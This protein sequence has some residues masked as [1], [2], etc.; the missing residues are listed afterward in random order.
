MKTSNNIICLTSAGYTSVMMAIK[1]QEWYPNHN[2]INVMA[3]TSKERIESLEFMNECDKFFGLNL[4]WIESK[5][6]ET[7]G[8][9]TDFNITSFENLKTKGEIFEEGIKNMEYH[10]K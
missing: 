8:G 2:I 1:M 5:I 7:K 10:L 4:V 3:N 6:N 9:S